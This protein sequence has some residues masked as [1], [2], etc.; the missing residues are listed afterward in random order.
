MGR[1]RPC[2]TTREPSWPPRSVEGVCLL[3]SSGLSP[4]GNGY[5]KAIVRQRDESG[6]ITPAQADLKCRIVDP[7]GATVFESQVT[8]NAFGSL[9]GQWEIASDAPLGMYRLEL[10]EKDDQWVANHTLFRVED[11]L[12]EMKLSPST[13]PTWRRVRHPG[14]A[15][16]GRFCESGSPGFLLFWWPS[17]RCSGAGQWCIV[18]PTR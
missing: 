6:Y 8:L 13:G 3:R 15:A 18:G 16:S 2:C 14:S 11:K 1:T 7:R 10:K 5:W 17:D 12:P 9:H 4:G